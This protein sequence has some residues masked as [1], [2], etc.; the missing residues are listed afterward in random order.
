MDDLQKV[1]DELGVTFNE[2]LNPTINELDQLMKAIAET[3]LTRF[4]ET[5]NGQMAALRAEFEIFDITDP[6]KQLEKLGEVMS[7]PAFGAPA[8]R[9]ALAGLDL[10]TPEGRAAAQKMVEDLFT[11]LQTGSL[12]PSALGTLTP[13][14]FLNALRDLES[15]IVLLYS[16]SR[17]FKSRKLLDFQSDGIRNS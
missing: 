17:F 13:E 1:A 7:N 15:A 14:E 11:A 5:F 3:E 9:A 10:S 2:K 8:L 12:D 4:A 16:Y 6:I